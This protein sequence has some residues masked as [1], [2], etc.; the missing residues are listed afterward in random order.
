MKHIAFIC[1]QPDYDI[2][3]RKSAIDSILW[4]ILSELSNNYIITV[5]GIAINNLSINKPQ[6]LT[7]NKFTIKKYIPGFIKNKFKIYKQYKANKLYFNSLTEKPDILFELLTRGSNVGYK[8]KLK[9]NVPYIIYYDSPIAYQYKEIFDAKVP[10]Y[11]VQNEIKSLQQASG[12]VTYSTALKQHIINISN[13]NAQINIFQTLDYTRLKSVRHTHLP[14]NKLT[15]GF[16]GSFM[17]WHRVD[18]LIEAFNRL[19]K[20]Y[21]YIRL[22]VVGS[23]ERYNEC[24]TQAKKSEYFNDIIFTGFADGNKLDEYKSQIDIGVMPGSNWYGIPTK[25]FEYGAC[26]IASIAPDTPTI[27]EIFTNNKDILLFEKDNLNDFTDKLEKL[28]TDLNFRNTLAANLYNKIMTE[29]TLER[30]K[31]FYINLFNKYL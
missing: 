29:H 1:S 10:R 22:L 21:N 23:G 25:V 7:Y 12:I 26:S 17:P 18:M 11:Y 6:N 16:I 27:S 8:L 13:T 30:A 24:F 19:K 15:I 3:N 20:K 4:S 2:T 31:K 14:G 28:I 5:N 9:F